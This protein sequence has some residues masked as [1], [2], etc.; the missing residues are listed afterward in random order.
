[1][2]DAFVIARNPGVSHQLLMYI[3][4]RMQ[5]MCINNLCVSLRNNG[6][7]LRFPCMC[8]FRILLPKTK[9]FAFYSYYGIIMSRDT[10]R[11]GRTDSVNY[12]REKV[13]SCRGFDC[14]NVTTL[15]VVSLRCAVN[16]SSSVKRTGT[17]VFRDEECSAV[18]LEAAGSSKLWKPICQVQKSL[19]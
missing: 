7:G 3:S 16:K 9:D 6:A 11:D 12:V 19:S 1:M 5:K 13:R 14:V 15:S 8:H 10:E 18:K 17:L 4:A 2:M